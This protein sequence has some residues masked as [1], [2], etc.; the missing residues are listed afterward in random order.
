M[1]NRVLP[2]H[3]EAAFFTALDNLYLSPVWKMIKKVD[4]SA[5]REGVNHQLERVDRIA[6]KYS[7]R[8]M[9]REIKRLCK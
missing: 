1:S 9:R 6:N 2:K 7:Q 3:K 4:E 8:F 5:R